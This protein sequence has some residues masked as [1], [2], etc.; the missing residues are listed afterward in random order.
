MI[1]AL[2]NNQSLKIINHEKT[3]LFSLSLF[4]AS[5]CIAQFTSEDF[6]REAAFVANSTL[7]SN[8]FNLPAHGTNIVWDFSVAFADETSTRQYFDATNDP[9]SPGA[10]NYRKR[11][12]IFQEFLIESNEYEGVNTDNLLVIGRSITDVTYL[13][14]AITVGA[15]DILRFVGGNYL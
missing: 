7:S 10:L 8:V 5:L 12:L 2:S 4:T 11:N 3:V 1:F 14:T 9:N 15:N 13:I 6:P